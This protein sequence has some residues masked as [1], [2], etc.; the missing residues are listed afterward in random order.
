MKSQQ[1]VTAGCPVEGQP[2][3]I[4]LRHLPARF[5]RKYSATALV[6]WDD[7]HIFYPGISLGRSGKDLANYF[8]CFGCTFRH[9]DKGLIGKI[10]VN[11]AEKIFG[12][13]GF[14]FFKRMDSQIEG[15][16]PIKARAVSFMR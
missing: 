1:K 14:K 5:L 2:S 10:G 11:Q 6:H 16:Y 12:H 7:V 9:F 4:G 15:S 3:M 8:S 13:L